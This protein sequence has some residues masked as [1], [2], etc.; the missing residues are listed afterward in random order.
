MTFAIWHLP[1]TLHSTL[2]SGHAR[3]CDT[4]T[5]ALCLLH[6]GLGNLSA[7]QGGM[8]NMTYL[9]CCEATPRI[10]TSEEERLRA[11]QHV[12]AALPRTAQALH[13]QARQLSSVSADRPAASSFIVTPEFSAWG[14]AAFMSR[15]ITTRVGTWPTGM[16]PLRRVYCMCHVTC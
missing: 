1:R 7:V 11:L 16:L 13:E 8:C 2:A 12:C 15:C 6:P 5:S 9:L 4:H 3:C 10:V 14:L